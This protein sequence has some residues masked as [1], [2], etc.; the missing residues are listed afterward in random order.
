MT[1]QTLMTRE[2][3]WVAPETPLKQAARIMV[4]RDVSGLPVCAADGTVVGVLSETDIVLREEG[5]AAHAAGALAWLLERGDQDPRSGATTA[6]EAMTAP[7]VTVGPGCTVAQAARLMTEHRV[8][9][10]PVVVDGRLVGIV[11]RSDLLR[12][13]VRSDAEIERE[14][15]ADV[16]LGTLWVTPDTIELAVSDGR[17]VLS[18][19]VETRTEAEILAAYVRRVPGVLDVDASA[20]IWLDDDLVRRR[21]LAHPATSN[22]S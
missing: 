18:G 22:W 8:R 7:A 9:R 15:L 6:G 17:V 5:Y 19:T 16:V 3:A 21:G 20:L 13:F 14:I 11:S 12:A 4:D 2:P 10:L 1:V